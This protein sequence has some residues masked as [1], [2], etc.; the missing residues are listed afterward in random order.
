MF[1]LCRWVFHMVTAALYLT[2]LG[3]EFYVPKDQH[4]W[5]FCH[6]EWN[7]QLLVPRPP[8]RLKYP[9]LWTNS[10]WRQLEVRYLS[11]GLYI[12]ELLH[13]LNWQNFC[14]GSLTLQPVGRLVT[15]RSP[16]RG[17]CLAYSFWEKGFIFA[18]N[19]RQCHNKKV[20]GLN[21]GCVE[22]WEEE[23]ASIILYKKFHSTSNQK[24]ENCLIFKPI[25]K[26]AITF[27]ASLKRELGRRHDFLPVRTA[28]AFVWFINKDRNPLQT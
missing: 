11:I 5:L 13:R 3:P 20:T 19:L 1:R 9:F 14:T 27:F 16:R 15:T 25:V 10:I 7:F 26:Y 8:P 6:R 22:I 28:N 23:C 18:R 17:R 2:G 12:K 24:L 4:S 21:L